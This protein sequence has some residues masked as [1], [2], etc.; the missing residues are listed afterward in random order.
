[1]V[2]EHFNYVRMYVI[3]SAIIKPFYFVTNDHTF[4]KRTC[5]RKIAL[6]IRLAF[7]FS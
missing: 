7:V 2:G 3:S 5:I 4:L 1:M 6:L